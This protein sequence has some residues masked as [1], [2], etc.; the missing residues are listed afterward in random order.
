MH[1]A[2][3]QFLAGIRAELPIAL[4]T[5]PF[6][7][8]FG[9]LALQ[10]G[11]PPTIA[12]AMSSVVF[13]GSAQFIGAQMIGEGNPMIV[14][15]LAT[16]IINIRHILYS[17]SLAPYARPLSSLWK[18]GLS[19][20]LTDE[21]FVPTVFHYEKT[22]DNIPPVNRAILLRKRVES[23][24]NDKRHWYWFGAGITLWTCWQLSTLTGII[25]GEQL[26]PSLDW[27]GFT[28]IITFIGMIVPTLKDRP[29]IG[30]F[31][32]AGLTAT[33]TNA[34]P[35]PLIN[36]YKLHILVGALA[37][38]IMGMTLEGMAVEQEQTE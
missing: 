9:V 24:R 3:P 7:I 25:I 20:L 34:L 32:A 38:I 11:I 1:K 12:L 17:A 4:S 36:Q 22:N 37:G 13:A 29:L 23:K 28:L 6:G 27:L 33:A 15:W 16:F 35:I 30:A 2:R 21:A 31:I 26:P 8:I 19:Y 14:L 5:L 18:V 10:N